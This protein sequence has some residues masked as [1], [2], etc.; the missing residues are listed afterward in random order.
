MKVLLVT[1]PYHCGMLEAAGSWLPLGPLYIAGELKKKGHEVVL[2]DAMTLFHGFEDVARVVEDYRPDVVGVGAITA[3]VKAA[4]EVCAVVKEVLPKAV[5]VLG[6]VHPTFMAEEVL[7]S[8]V[9]DF[10]IRGE[11][12]LTFAELLECLTTASRPEKVKGIAYLEEGRVVETGFR[13]F[14]RDLDSLTPAWDI[15]DWSLYTYHAK[16]GSR[17]AVVSSS[18]GCIGGCVFCSQRLFWKG[19]WRARSAEGFVSELEFLRKEYGVDVVMISDEYPTKDR[20]RW[21]RIL[22]LLIER[23]LGIEILMETRVNDIVRDEDILEKYRLAGVTH[24]YVGVEAPDQKRLDELNKDIKVEESKRAIELINGVDIVS[25]TSFVVGTPEET[26]E[27]LFATLELAK[28]YSPD[29]AFFLP[30]TPWPY[31][32]LFERFEEF[33]ET[34]DWSKYNLI[35]PVIRPI[36]MDRAE[37]KR[38]MMIATAEFFKH[39][40]KNLSSLTPFKRDFLL[41]VVRLILERSYLSEEMRLALE[42]L[43]EVLLKRAEVFAL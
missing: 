20:V 5:T 22:D 14:V 15:V 12:E 9:V 1:P 4:I 35:E 33:I 26:E 30:L 32:S 40:L 25:E 39:R 38:L 36:N 37:L 6:G 24:I 10:V 43:K 27:S 23:D 42:G 34:R 13:E 17:L 19:S 28:F 3:T 31:T 7:G 21:E 18:R 16:P 8:G 11:A 29:M 41:R 2:Y